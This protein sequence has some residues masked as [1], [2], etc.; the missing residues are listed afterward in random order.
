[1]LKAGKTHAQGAISSALQLL[2]QHS[3]DSFPT[4]SV[5]QLGDSR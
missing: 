1:M 4:R 3:A 5:D 2:P